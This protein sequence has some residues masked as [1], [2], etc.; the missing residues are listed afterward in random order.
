MEQIDLELLILSNEPIPV[1][2]INIYPTSI[3]EI[4][5]FG[6]T[7]YNQALKI[8]CI[9]KSEIKGLTGQEMSTFE[10]LQMN[11]TFD[12]NVKNLLIKILSL[13]CKKEVRYSELQNAFVI[14]GDL[15]NKSNFDEFISVVSKINCIEEN[16]IVENPSNEK[17]RQ[18]LEKRRKLRN[19]LI[20]SQKS[21][22][23][24]QIP[25]IVSVVATS[26]KM[27]ISYILKYNVYQLLDQFMRIISKET[28]ETNLNALLHGADSKDLELKHWTQKQ[29]SDN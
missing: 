15:I 18:L 23:L 22:N 29:P 19:K 4:A 28:Y 20:K 14:S 1:G 26:Q 24:L 7:E 5:K 13:I 8:L 9:S 12:E 16:E 6:Y 25:E 27:P 17:A 2:R 10:F 3:R 21:N 11:M